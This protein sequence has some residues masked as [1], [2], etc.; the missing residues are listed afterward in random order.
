MMGVLIHALCVC[1][2]DLVVVVDGM[3]WRRETVEWVTY[4]SQHEGVRNSS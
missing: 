2:C 1:V 4:R 3:G